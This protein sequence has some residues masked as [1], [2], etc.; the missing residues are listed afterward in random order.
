[1]I[2]TTTRTKPKQP[3]SM[4]GVTS[5]GWRPHSNPTLT[6]RQNT[7]VF[8]KHF[9][10]TSLT[11]IV[12]HTKGYVHQTQGG[13]L[14]P[15]FSAFLAGKSDLRCTAKQLSYFHL[16]ILVVHKLIHILSII[17]YLMCFVDV[18]HFTR[19]HESTTIPH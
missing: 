14:R 4:G 19:N 16:E 15:L 17:P 5:N 18:G 11:T 13:D 10:F 3:G 1:M 8:N 2:R 9:V 12:N 6:Q 7:L